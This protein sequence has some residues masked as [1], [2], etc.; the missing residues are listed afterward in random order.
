MWQYNVILYV[1]GLVEVA[2]VYKSVD[3]QFDTVAG[4]GQ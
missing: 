2:R 4:F 1:L 3:L